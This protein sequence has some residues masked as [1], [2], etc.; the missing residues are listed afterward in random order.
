MA[1]RD[2]EGAASAGSVGDG[3]LRYDGAEISFHWATAI[4]VVV[5]YLLSQGWG[6][7]ERGSPLRHGMQSVHVSLGLLLAAVVGLRILWR[8][9]PGRRLP[10]ASTG[11]LELA[12]KLVHYLLYALLVVIVVLGFFY[13][14]ANGDPL[15]FFG[16]FT[17]PSPASF[18]KEQA[19]TIGNLHYWVGTAIIVIAGLHASAALFHRLV[20]RDGVLSRM[21]PGR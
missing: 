2:T 6:F 18:T 17:I 19:H 14:W 9:G 3:L 7:V 1:G 10:P 20:L 5:L 11:L 16:L 8:L 21:L 12:A 4:L 15:S 13:R